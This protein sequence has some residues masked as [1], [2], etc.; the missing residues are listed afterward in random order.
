M[1][2]LGN[3]AV[4]AAKHEGCLLQIYNDK[5][6]IHTGSGNARKSF[7]CNVWDDNRILEIVNILNFGTKEERKVS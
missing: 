5:A 1:K 7:I 3:L 2:Q 4:V 6:I